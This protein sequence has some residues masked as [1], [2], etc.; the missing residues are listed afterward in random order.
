MLSAISTLILIYLIF[1]KKKYRQ[2]SKYF[3][4][5]LYIFFFQFI[6]IIFNQDVKLTL[7]IVFY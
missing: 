5:I 3:I 4:F 7:E 6:G 2:L 1:K